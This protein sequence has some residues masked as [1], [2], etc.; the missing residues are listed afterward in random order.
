VALFALGLLTVHVR[1]DWRLLHEDNGALHTTLAL[2]HVALGLGQSRAH[3]VF[4]DPRTGERTPYAHHPPG[5]PLILAAIFSG[6]RGAEPVVARSAAIAFHLASGLLLFSLLRRYFPFRDTVLG[7][8]LFATLPMSAY[9]GRSVNFEAFC[10]PFVLLQLDAWV[11]WRRSGSRSAAA[12]LAAAAILGAAIDWA[13]L[14]FTLS[15]AASETVGGLARR[16]RRLAAG[17]GIA[18]LAAA[19]FLLDVAHISYASRGG[20]DSLWRVL[21]SNEASGW[22]TL[23][24][25]DFALGQVENFRLYFTHAGLLAALL[26]V[27]V[28]LRPRTRLSARFFDRTDAAGLR[29]LLAVS[30]SAAAAYCLAAPKWADV[31]VFWQFYFLPFV[32]IGLLLLLRGL[33]R[34]TIATRQWVSRLALAWCVVDVLA[35]SAYQ[36][37]H[38]HTTPSEYAIAKT[39]EFRAASLPPP[40]PGEPGLPSAGARGSSRSPGAP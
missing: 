31:H 18:A 3:N 2:S 13:S 36:I 17:A 29:R 33:A 10:L 22:A 5:A 28:L 11:R 14:F 24:S 40:R 26:T 39:A 23:A 37:H 21:G 9:F 27:F 20:L 19:A 34:G 15:I 8:L 7:V 12:A 4:V 25:L 32:V 38:R 35:V 16:P 1:S 30:G 6:V